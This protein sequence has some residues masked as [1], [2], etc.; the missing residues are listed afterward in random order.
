MACR[1]H[2]PF[3]LFFKMTCGA[4]MSF[5]KHKTCHH[6]LFSSLFPLFRSRIPSNYPSSHILSPSS[7]LLSSLYSIP[8]SFSHLFNPSP[9]HLLVS[10]SYSTAAHL[11]LPQPLQPPLASDPTWFPAAGFPSSLHPILIF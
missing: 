8:S 11:L 2:I 3:S 6:F 1:H 5:L 9:I 7:T 4:H 10:T